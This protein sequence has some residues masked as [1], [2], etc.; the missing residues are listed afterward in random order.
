MADFKHIEF[1]VCRGKRGREKFEAQEL[2]QE[3]INK[4]ITNWL[5]S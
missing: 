4:S 1:W 5:D 3:E 2:T